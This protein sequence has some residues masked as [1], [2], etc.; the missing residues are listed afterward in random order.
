[1][2]T[3][4]Y[5]VYFSDLFFASLTRAR[6]DYFYGMWEYPSQVGLPVYHRALKQAAGPPVCIRT[7]ISSIDS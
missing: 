1:M 5:L 2:Y 6:A 7:G 4:T 3:S